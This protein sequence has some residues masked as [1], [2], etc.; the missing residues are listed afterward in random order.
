VLKKSED[1]K[2][3]VNQIGEVPE[4][5][6]KEF[7]QWL[8]GVSKTDIYK[9]FVEQRIASGEWLSAELGNM[10]TASI[11]FSLMSFI[12]QSEGEQSEILQMAYGSGSKSKVFAARITCAKQARLELKNRFQDAMNSRVKLGIEEYERIHRAY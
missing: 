7:P 3:I 5:N 2:D 6:S 4:E 11:F 8:K 9:R 1:L 12:A 10:Y